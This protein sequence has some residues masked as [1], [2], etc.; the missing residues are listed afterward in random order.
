MVF[1]FDL[2]NTLLDDGAAQARYLPLLYHRFKEYI[3]CTEGD[4]RLRWKEALPKYHQLYAE[5][6]ISFE[7]QRILRVRDSFNNPTLS[8]DIVRSIIG[9]FDDLF[10]ESWTLFPDTLF[11]LNS[12][13]QYPLGIITNGSASQQ[14]LKI[15]RTGLRPYF[16]CILISEELGI[17]KP[18]KEIFLHACQKL[19]CLPEEC[20]F[21]GDSWEN[22]VVG[23]AAAGMNAVWF[24]HERKPLPDSGIPTRSIYTLS[25]V[26]NL[27]R[28]FCL[29]S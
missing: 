10:S 11:V 13:R 3:L 20:Y 4:F 8:N 15:D 6:K 5:R 9:T 27:P 25:E 18:Q 24:N 12:L 17:A 2:D 21:I 16:D 19:Q 23:S 26:L 28:D 14:A 1:F 22:D 29:H 7:E